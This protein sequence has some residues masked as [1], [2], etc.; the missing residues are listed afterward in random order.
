MNLSEAHELID[1]LLDKAD[2]PYFIPE[3][4]TKFLGLAISDFINFHYQKMEADEDSRRAIAGCIRWIG[5]S[6][7]SSEILS[8]NN[9][10]NN[11]Y[12]ALSL[13]YDDST[14]SD[15]VGFFR[16]GNQYV[17]P[18]RHLYT[19]A[20]NINTYNYDDVINPSTG[21]PYQGVTAS[22]I[23]ISKGVSVKNKS[24]RDFYE[25]FYTEDPFSAPDAANPYWQYIENRITIRSDS[26][27][28]I[29]NLQYISMQVVLLPTVEE[30]FSAGTQ[31]NS[32]A[33]AMYVFTE[34]YQ[35]QIVQ[36]AVKK[37]TQTDV[38][39]MTPPS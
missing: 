32:S 14:S 6:L 7:S 5:F 10:Y 11:N 17:L 2:Q 8:G 31:Q 16:M 21:L 15:H 24:T 28:G 34:H 12:P 36:I 1:I 23:V 4:K 25:D 38:G 30:A 19:I 20:M 35:K 3:E 22:D 39:L 33:P 18:K 29:R 26:D 9:I 27:G 13:K 37:M